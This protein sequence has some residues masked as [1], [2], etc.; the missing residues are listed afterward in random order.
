[1]ETKVSFIS[2]TQSSVDSK[3]SIKKGQLVFTTDTKRIYLDISDTERV[4]VGTGEYENVIT[5]EEV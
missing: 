5:I 4:L 2:T 1:M 3:K